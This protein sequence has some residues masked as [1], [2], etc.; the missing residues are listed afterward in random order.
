MMTGTAVSFLLMGVAVFVYVVLLSFLLWM[1]VDAAK[2]DKFWW[3]VLILILP[4]LGAVIYYFTEKQHDYVKMP[5][6][7]NSSDKK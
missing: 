5:G 4:I 3:I 6:A 2:Q 7:R 1:L